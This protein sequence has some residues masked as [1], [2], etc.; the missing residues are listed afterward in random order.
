MATE[1]RIIEAAKEYA[2]VY[3]EDPESDGWLDRLD[4]SLERLREAVAQ[5]EH[6]Q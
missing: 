1:T 3:R 4:A 6:S 5:H 2:A